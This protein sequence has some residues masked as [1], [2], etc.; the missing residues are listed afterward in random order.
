[1][2]PALVA[3]FHEIVEQV[4]AVV[5]RLVSA[6]AEMGG[7]AGASFGGAEAEAVLKQLQGLNQGEWK[8]DRLQ[9]RLSHAN[10]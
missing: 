5:E 1:M 8:A 7:L 3:G 10:L 4:L 9:R 6:A 2:H